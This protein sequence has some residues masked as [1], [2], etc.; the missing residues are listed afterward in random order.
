MNIL[1]D[2]IFP[3]SQT[4]ASFSNHEFE[5]AGLA[6]LPIELLCR[7]GSFL[8]TPTDRLH[9]SILSKRFHTLTL[10]L[11]KNDALAI[12]KL[13][14]KAQE[15]D[16]ELSKTVRSSLS[17]VVHH[18]DVCQNAAKY[19]GLFFPKVTHLTLRE[20][21][22]LSEQDFIN[23]LSSCP[24]VT[25]ISL[26]FKLS[27]PKKYIEILS[28]TYP[29]LLELNIRYEGQILDDTEEL[30]ATS[31]P[32]LQ[33]FILE[34][35]DSEISDKFFQNHPVLKKC[36]LSPSVTL[37]GKALFLKNQ[38]STN[39]LEEIEVYKST[40]TDEE[41]LELAK[42][43]PN[44][45]KFHITNLPNITSQDTIA[46][47]FSSCKSLE[48]IA[49]SKCTDSIAD[50]IAQNCT[51]LKH[52]S[53][54]MSELTD[55]GFE[56]IIT[57]LPHLQSIQL[58][59]C[60]AL[61]EKCIDLI[62][63]HSKELRDLHIERC[64]S[65]DLGNLDKIISKVPTI[66]K[67]N[68]RGYKKDIHPTFLNSRGLKK[69]TVTNNDFFD[70]DALL[71]LSEAS[72]DRLKKIDL[73]GCNSIT[74]DG[75]FALFENCRKLKKIHLPSSITFEMIQKMLEIIPQSVRSLS[76]EETMKGNKEWKSTTKYISDKKPTAFHRI[77]QYEW[78]G[79]A[80][81]YIYDFIN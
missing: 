57:S 62:S 25:S 47:F 23:I 50:H 80:I 32:G 51:N 27:D 5:N 35:S 74:S 24:K 30:I 26:K 45:R 36:I 28:K 73:R 10:D 13:F 21:A 54:T 64:R 53:L 17:N 81:K 77:A 71:Q 22:Q 12:E 69:F 48:S 31:F 6:T 44:L 75:V 9:Y 39:T 79:P 56:K 43:A 40:L 61:S 15:S 33:T 76:C 68:V 59:A 37:A 3:S 49:I 38:K 29:N 14:A 46:T 70:D 66:A 67:V 34:N 63:I 58:I 65:L 19:K 60:N 4:N 18:L 52:L 7:I 20:S 16:S 11:I 55:D 72:K 1:T 78:F 41:L 8:H 2:L 42:Q